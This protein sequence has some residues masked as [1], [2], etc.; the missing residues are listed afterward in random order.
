[1]KEEIRHLKTSTIHQKCPSIKKQWY[2]FV[3]SVEKIQKVKAKL[4]S[5]NTGRI[6]SLSKMK[7][8]VDYRVF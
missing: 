8:L 2:C 7:K 5:I 4:V 6:I 1:M 3:G